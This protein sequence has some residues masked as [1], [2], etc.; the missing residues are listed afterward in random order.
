[1]KHPNMVLRG[2]RSIRQYGNLVVFVC[3]FS[4]ENRH[5]ERADQHLFVEGVET[6]TWVSTLVDDVDL[7]KKLR[8]ILINNY[9][10]FG[11]S[12]RVQVAGTRKLLI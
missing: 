11:F 3:L 6:Q 5:V 4:R 12:V 2:R 10:R 1:M 9:S 7:A 8:T